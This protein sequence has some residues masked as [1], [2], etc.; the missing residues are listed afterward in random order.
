MELFIHRTQMVKK[1][2]L[3]ADLLENVTS[4][5]GTTVQ[6][7]ALKARM[8]GEYKRCVGPFTKQHGSTETFNPKRVTLTPKIS[9]DLIDEKL[10][11][12]TIMV[13][14]SIPMTLILS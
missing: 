12:E 13:E 10:L 11:P 2:L 8:S 5:M 1:N 14:C 4:M 6:S 3:F 9:R 7:S